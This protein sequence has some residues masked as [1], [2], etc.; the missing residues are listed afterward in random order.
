MR[1]GGQLTGVDVL[2][3]VQNNTDYFFI[4]RFLTA[5]D[6]GL[7]TLGFRLPELLVLNL[8]VVTGKVLFPAFAAIDRSRPFVRISRVTAS[9]RVRRSCCERNPDVVRWR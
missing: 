7:Y 4:G 5:A 9:N 2:A 8:A 3:A 6:L 1:F